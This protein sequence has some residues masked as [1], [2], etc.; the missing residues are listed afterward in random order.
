[1]TQQQKH[2]HHSS[3]FQ[4][5]QQSVGSSEKLGNN[6]C[7]HIF[8]ITKFIIIFPIAT[9]LKMWFPIHIWLP[10]GKLT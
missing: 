4:Q 9:P 5:N 2:K 6:N 8:S 1:M 10:S 3:N 7:I